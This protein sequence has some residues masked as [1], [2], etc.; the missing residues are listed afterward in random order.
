MIG[1]L[2]KE[3]AKEADHK[4]YCDKEFGETKTKC[5]EL[6]YDI[7]NQFGNLHKSITERT[8]LKDDV[9]QMQRELAAFA[10]SRAA[11]TAVRTVEHNAYLDTKKDLE[12]GVEGTRVALKV[13]CDYYAN[14][15]ENSFSRNA[16]EG[17]RH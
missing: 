9:M 10:K 8:R 1:K 11:V 17:Q 15:A 5:D 12:L 14:Q 7:A 16:L 2:E 3:A 13:L 6:N 4:A